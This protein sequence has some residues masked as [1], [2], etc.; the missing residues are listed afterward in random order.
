MP[1]KT[2]QPAQPAEPAPATTA[3]LVEARDLWPMPEA[4]Y[5]LGVSIRGLYALVNGG[6]L[7][8]VRVGGRR[9]VAD[10][11]LKRYVQALI[12]G[13]GGGGAR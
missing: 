8:T 10:V 12:V 5:R 3:D 2:A 13:G 6:D 7:A 9:F 11:E 4:A 1:P